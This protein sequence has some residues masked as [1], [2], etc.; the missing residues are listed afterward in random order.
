MAESPKSSPKDVKSKK[1]TVKSPETFRERAVK[2]SEV[3][4][5]PSVAPRAGSF[6][7]R[8]IKAIF[9]PIGRFLKW[10]FRLKIM[11]P[12]RFIGRILGKIFFAHYFVESWD[13]LRKVT[14]PGWKQSRQ[15]TFAVLVFAVIFGVAIAIVDYAL[16]KIF[17]DILLK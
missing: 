5:K 17:R 8:V 14:W 11:A 2:A 12:V 16:D 6:I 7:W 13:E 10:L 9:R 4:D 15:L 1:R 3:G